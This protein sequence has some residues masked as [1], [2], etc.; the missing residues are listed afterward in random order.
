M[1]PRI[2]VAYDFGP[3][4]QRAL[5]W[6]AELQQTIATL[7]VYVVH[8]LNPAPIASPDAIVPMLSEEDVAGVRKQL[9]QDVARQGV[10]AAAQVVL[11]PDAAGAILA[12]ANRVGANLIAMGTHGRTGLSR[13]VLGSVAEQVIRHAPCAVVTIRAAADGHSA[14]QAA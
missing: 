8:V 3:A 9:E 14:A 10:S 1:Q 12:E 7:P 4:S 6:A 5:V 2:L 13:V 11:A